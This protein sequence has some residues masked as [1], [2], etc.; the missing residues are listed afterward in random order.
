MACLT[1]SWALIL[2]NKYN[3][4]IQATN[5]V[6]FTPLLSAK[7]RRHSIF[8]DC[9]LHKLM[10]CTCCTCLY[11]FYIPERDSS[12]LRMCS[13]R[14]STSWTQA[15]LAGLYDASSSDLRSYCEREKKNFN[16]FYTS[17]HFAAGGALDFSHLHSEEAA[18]T[19]RSQCL[20]M[21]QPMEEINM[22]VNFRH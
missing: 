13:T 16:R 8:K 4:V 12:Y 7:E 22:V 20:D 21:L 2:L 17:I 6:E 10:F 14:L 18:Q 19:S 3:V 15:F 5:R 1:M 9:Y 11:R